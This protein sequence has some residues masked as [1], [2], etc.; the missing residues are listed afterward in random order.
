MNESHPSGGSFPADSSHGFSYTAPHDGQYEQTAHSGYAQQGQH[1]AYDGYSTGTATFD[2][3]YSADS[4]GADPL[5]GSMPGQHTGMENA[6]WAQGTYDA[7]AYDAYADPAGASGTYGGEYGGAGHHSGGY[8]S[9][10]YDTG[11]YDSGSYDSGAYTSGSY[12]QDAAW[13]QAGFPQTADVPAQH[14]ADQGDFGWTHGQWDTSQWN[15][16]Q[17][18]TDGQWDF[19]GADGG[20]D[21]YGYGGQ[22][23]A[24]PGHDG[25]SADAYDTYDTYG[26]FEAHQSAESYESAEL[27]TSYDS[28]EPGAAEDYAGQGQGQGQGQQLPYADGAFPHDVEP[29]ATTAMPALDGYDGYDSYDGYDVHGADAPAYDAETGPDLAGYEGHED[30]DGHDGLDDY[31]SH[32]GD[33]AHGALPQGDLRV[34]NLPGRRRSPRP[35][36]SALL[37]VAVP[38]V[39]VMGVAAAAAAS[40]ADSVPQEETTTQAADVPVKPANK[41]LDTQLAGLS[42]DADDFADRASR[43][44]ERLDL[45]ARQE[46]ERKRKAR[47]AARKEALRPKFALPV[48]EHGLS[49]TFGQAG[50]N[51]MSVHTGIDFP[52]SEGTTV[53]AA[54]D[55]TVTTKYDVAF[56][57]MAVVTAPDGT[58][59][60]YCHLSSTKIRSGQVKA[61]DAI[62]Y[63]GTSGNSTGPHLHFEVHPGGGEAIDPL[64]WL[65][66]KGLNP[67]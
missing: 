41:K 45:Q 28:Y 46:A 2:H 49:A 64:P 5:F 34:P 32:D 53:M 22:Q 21:A 6:S 56:G 11:T 42:A 61:G 25:A 40:V 52:V 47:E 44:Q 55:G 62:A 3:G 12:G 35:R 15:N 26:S 20:W 37:T 38:S 4:Y 19:T 30:L 59:T 10:G 31:D 67:Q 33:D 39:A 63:S 58:E 57:N 51:W 18:E 17:W 23:T 54:T 1:A 65:R 13:A 14:G 60:W 29:D 7:G 24:V 9:T 36:R 66:G 16:A 8:D 48:Q 50:L 27:Y 43:T